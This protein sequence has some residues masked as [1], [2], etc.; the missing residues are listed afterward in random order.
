MCEA[1]PHHLMKCDGGEAEGKET[2][3]LTDCCE[4]LYRFKFLK[5]WHSKTLPNVLEGANISGES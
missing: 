4:I 2:E 5:L 1:T 3:I